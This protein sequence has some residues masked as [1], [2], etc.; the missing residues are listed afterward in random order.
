MLF[1]K[2]TISRVHV[3]PYLTA[4]ILALATCVSG[5]VLDQ[6]HWR[7][8]LPQGNALHNVIFTNGTY[9]AVGELGTILTS[10][11]GTNWVRQESGTTDDLR[12][13]AYGNGLYV[14]VGGFG[15][16]LTSA[17]AVSWTPQFAGTFYSLNA[18]TYSEGQFVAVGEQTTI[19]TSADGEIWTLRASG[20]WDLID[21]AQAEG[22]FVAVGGKIPDA[23]TAAIS[24]ILTSS[25][26]QVWTRRLFSEGGPIQSVTYGAGEFVAVGGANSYSS[27]PIWT[28]ED[29]INWQL[30]TQLTSFP[31]S[32][33]AYGA[34][35]WVAAAEAFYNPDSGLGTIYVSDDLL[36]WSLVVS[37]TFPVGG[38]VFGNGQFIA[39]RED[40]TFLASSN[41]LAWTNPA[42]E[43]ALPSFLND[44]QY[45][46]GA[47]VGVGATQIV[48]SVD[49]NL[50]TN[51]VAVT[52]TGTLTSITYGNGRYV[53]GG[54]SRTVWTS[55]DG[56]NWTNP[57]P[58]LS[59]PYFADVAVAYGNGAFVAVAGNSGDVLTSFDGSNW[60][61]RQ[62]ETNQDAPIY[63]RD[64]TY[65]NGRFVAVSAQAVAS[66]SDGVTWTYVRTNQG[67][68]HVCS[69]NGK[70]V[71]VG[72]FGTIGTSTD[73]TNWT[74]NSSPELGPLWDVAFGAGYF[75]AVGGDNNGAY[76]G[77]GSPILISQDGVHWEKRPSHTPKILYHVA[78]G[79]G[80]FVIS[81]AGNA[82]LQSDPLVELAVEAQPAPRL[83]ISGP[84]N[85]TYRIDWTDA[86][87]SPPAWSELTNL[88]IT[89]S[90]AQ[91]VDP[92]W[93]NRTKCFY[94]AMLLP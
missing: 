49:G 61:V 50:W 28:S 41:G 8:P 20:E 92:S 54:E 7:N 73:G 2:K 66:S 87:G 19:L 79:D 43:P 32:C 11:D 30:K 93:T 89:Q 75:V 35:K 80:T 55:V 78:F 77:V 68:F 72:G 10:P 86:W 59:T 13:C 22:I 31:L 70:F 39:S 91:Y 1:L 84:V 25:N 15:T 62:L 58:E 47:F 81:G 40:G 12:D 38:M 3:R 88:N 9:L 52:N 48:Q 76:L 37:N 44:L 67:L 16:V 51:S 90:P 21:V 6:W 18:I 74:I 64:V 65:G 24:V 33:V 14:A 69:G 63:F 17:D 29:G 46:N 83:F 26:G 85:R 71:A 27:A 4:A 53:A 45:L 60:T 36:N 42:P 94:R 5:A 57:A 23:S 56:V 34:G 82:V